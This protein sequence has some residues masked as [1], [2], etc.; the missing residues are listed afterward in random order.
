MYSVQ[1]AFVRVIER[2]LIYIF[3]M[4]LCAFACSYRFTVVISLIYDTRKST[5]KYFVN[6]IFNSFFRFVC[7]CSK[8]SWKITLLFSV[9][10]F[11]LTGDLLIF[12]ICQWVRK[13]EYESHKKRSAPLTISLSFKLMKCISLGAFRVVFVISAEYFI[14]C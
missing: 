6:W 5:M 2:R 8:K 10:S 3:Y 11:F 7:C 1:F 4:L 13:N 12:V 9:N 14:I